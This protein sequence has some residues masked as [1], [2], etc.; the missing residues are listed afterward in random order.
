MALNDIIY[1]I[2]EVALP[3]VGLSLFS[4]ILALVLTLVLALWIMP[5]L[6][7][8]IKALWYYRK[9]SGPNGFKHE[10]MFYNAKKVKIK[11]DSMPRNKGLQ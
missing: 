11:N 10:I 1:N 2:T 5:S 8:S 7:N 9:N 6:F 4:I 3:E